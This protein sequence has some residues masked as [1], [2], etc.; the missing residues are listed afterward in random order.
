MNDLS[1][2]CVETTSLLFCHVWTGYPYV[3]LIMFWY[4]YIWNFYE[5]L[6]E[7]MIVFV[8]AMYVIWFCISLISVFACRV[9]LVL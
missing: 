5:L 1:T 8:M 4:L 2:L 6:T 7:S 9:Y 3:Q